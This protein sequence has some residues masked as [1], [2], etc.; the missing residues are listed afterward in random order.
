MC[1]WGPV[2]WTSTGSPLAGT[3]RGTLASVW[4]KGSAPASFTGRGKTLVSIY[5][6]YT[7]THIYSFRRC[8]YSLHNIF[9]KERWNKNIPAHHS[10]S[11][12]GELT[13]S[14][15]EFML[16]NANHWQYRWSICHRYIIN[17]RCHTFKIPVTHTFHMSLF[18]LSEPPPPPLQLLNQ[19]NA[20]SQWTAHSPVEKNTCNK[21]FLRTEPLCDGSSAIFNYGLRP[22]PVPC[23]IEVS[24]R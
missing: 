17:I 10:S 20:P 11:L 19:L 3:S 13:D 1:P 16:M 24:F 8:K 6:Y 2:A 22:H 23:W 5:S 15:S 14:P 9:F 7:N 21:S 4:P 18:P 12:Q